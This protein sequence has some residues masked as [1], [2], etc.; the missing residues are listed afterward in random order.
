[1]KI[2]KE[3]QTKYESL[4]VAQVQLMG[5][6]TIRD[7]IAHFRSRTKAGAPRPP[8]K[9]EATLA[10][11][12]LNRGDVLRFICDEVYSYANDDHITTLNRAIFAEHSS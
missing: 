12:Y 6:G 9:C 3:H 2:T 10:F 5:F 8:I 1:M 11:S 4:L 7:F